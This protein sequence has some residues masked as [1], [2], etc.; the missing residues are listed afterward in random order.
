[1]PAILFSAR[2]C[3]SIPAILAGLAAALGAAE[4]PPV[5]PGFTRIFDGKGLD[6]WKVVNGK[7]E[8]WRAAD[9]VL[10]AASGGNWIA[11]KEPL[12][13]FILRLDFKVSRGGNSGVF[14][15]VPDDACDDPWIRGFEAQITH[16]VRDPEHCTGTLY[17]V[18]GVE[19]LLS[20][21]GGPEWREAWHRDH[22]SDG[23][24]HAY[25]IVCLGKRITV[26][27]DSVECV[28]A[29]ADAV[30][31]MASRPLKGFIGLQDSHAGPGSAIAFKNVRIAKLDAGGAVA[32]FTPIALDAK[33][34]KTIR[35]GHGSGGDWQFAGGAWVGQQDPPGSGNGGVL[36]SDGRYGDFELSIEAYPDWGCDSGIFLRSTDRGAC[37]QIM[38][39][40][41]GSGNVGSIY[42]EGS[43]GF[44]NRNYNLTPEKGIAPVERPP[45]NI[46]FPIEPSEWRRRWSYDGFNEVRARIRGNPPVI[47]V[48]LNGVYITR[49]EDD[50]KRPQL[51]EDGKGHV[52]IQVHGGKSWPA[53]AKVRYRNV[54]VR[55]LGGR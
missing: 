49:F 52:G 32:G 30:P 53:G 14:V 36:V 7:A 26:R 22:E 47:E 54:Q 27:V 45:G 42:G 34:W 16:E 28:D 11:Y 41:H 19:K 25:E 5:E 48:W 37:Y 43:G 31:A 10:H 13:D 50:Q 35:T 2:R 20:K 39:D 44:S 24:W 29:S 1:M 6:G 55:D 12:G 46:P 3:L 51:A 17:G 33:A 8:S 38:V 15:R 21:G 40:H 4:L 18:A 9:G 23:V